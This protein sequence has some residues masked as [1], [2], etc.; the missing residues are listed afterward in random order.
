MFI[1][2]TAA[3][4]GCFQSCQFLQ[5]NGIFS[6]RYGLRIDSDFARNLGGMCEPAYNRRGI[7]RDRGILP[8]QFALTGGG[9]VTKCPSRLNSL[10]TYAPADGT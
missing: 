10:D 4:Q 1:P 7:F 6:I 5:S 2:A 3:N 8:A 9:H